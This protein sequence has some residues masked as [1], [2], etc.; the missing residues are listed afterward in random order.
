[1]AVH[2]P[3]LMKPAIKEAFEAFLLAWG[4]RLIDLTDMEITQLI[5]S[6]YRDQLLTLELTRRGQKII[7]PPARLN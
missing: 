6:Y 2:H 3:E 4:F 7:L 5:Q 1:M